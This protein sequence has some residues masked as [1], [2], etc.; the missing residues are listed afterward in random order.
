MDLTIKDL[1]SVRMDTFEACSKWYD[2][3]LDLGIPVYE[4]DQIQHEH[5]GKTMECHRAML[6]CWLNAGE[7]T[8]WVA[9][10]EVLR[11]K[12]VEENSLAQKLEEKLDPSS[13]KPEGGGMAGYVLYAHGRCILETRRRGGW[14][15]NT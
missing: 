5:R 11:S 3:G 8:T 6:K 13:N 14:A 4:L 2:V 12:V 1:G 7:N 15:Y 9:L 10:I